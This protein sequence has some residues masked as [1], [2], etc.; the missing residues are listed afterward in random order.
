MRGRPAPL[1]LLLTVSLV[2]C[3]GSERTV[4]NAPSVLLITLDTTRADRLG[5]YGH[6]GAATPVL[7]RLAAEGALAEQAVS[8]SP[9]TLPSHA[10][11]LTGLYP[12][13]HG[14]RENADFRLPDSA[15]TLAEHLQEQ[16]YRTA[17]AV[18]SV[19]LASE[20][21]LAQGFEIYDEVDRPSDDP[22]DGQG[23]VYRSILERDARQ[24]TDS[25]LEMLDRLQGGP[26]FVW[27]HYFDPHAGYEPPSPW[28]ERFAA[29][30][31]DGEIAF[32]DSEI[33]R[34]LDGLD[35]RGLAA[36]TLIVATADHGE[37]LGEHGED[38]HGIFLYEATTRVPLLLRFP[39]RIPPGS[40]I[41]GLVAGVDVAPT[42]LDL[43][44]QPPLQPSEGVSFAPQLEGIAPGER[45]PVYAE[46]I[47]PERA[48]GWSPLYSLRDRSTR[49]VEAPEPELY[50][51]TVDPAERDNLAAG[52]VEEVAAWRTRLA[53]IVASFETP[54]A[55]AD[56]AMDA[57]ALARLEAL[58]YV[59]AGGPVRAPPSGADPKRM[60]GVHNRF[61][62][63]KAMVEAGRIDE[64]ARLLEEVLS[65]D[66]DNP[67]AL[68]LSGTILFARGE[69]ERGLSRL[70][71]AAETA[72]GV[73]EI[74][75]NLANALHAAGRLA[76]AERAFR[77]LLA[78]EPDSVDAHYALAN[79]L[80]AR[81]DGAAAIAEY[82]EAI[83]LGPDRPRV[84]VAL[85][86]TLATVGDLVSA[87]QQYREAL[88][89][90]PGLAVAWNELGIL[91]ER[92][93][94]H[95]EALAHYARALDLDPRLAGALFNHAKLSAMLGEL[96]TAFEE[97]RRL[98]DWYPDYAAG[99]LLLARLHEVRGEP[100]AARE[101]LHRVLRLAEGKD[102]G[103]AR[104]A[105]QALEALG[106]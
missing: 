88:D 2:S 31:Y 60:V 45:E 30:P 20:L 91:I 99:W 75:R 82:R 1:L 80:F 78:L 16:G 26:F 54:A 89:L 104:R 12:P 93:G 76:D 103:M 97:T 22:V 65:D 25:A 85:G 59:S 36:D 74:Q 32:M 64:G 73:I 41:D 57:E 44:G 77:A 11:L 43:L 95:S 90:D 13:S 72:P 21:G 29:D 100:G 50:D 96:E 35:G 102:P 79:V 39:G 8:V 14:V 101:A 19:V 6:V 61:L 27:V 51:L 18:A 34:L 69:R 10:S 46:S 38:T 92:A 66:P 94:R 42:I 58:G 9:M 81:G 87:E 106:G 24:V 70:E 98:V 62:R 15:R 23:I 7:D 63:A 40:R 5:C 56:H 48:Y 105:R 52:R 33:G 86:R 84:R 67:R 28:R 3:G 68:G 17:A 53:E 83:R 71:R 49:F 55:S 4:P 47:Y 37:S